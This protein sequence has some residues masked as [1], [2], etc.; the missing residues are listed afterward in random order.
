MP[1]QPTSL[2]KP[3]N[4]IF[5]FNFYAVS[6]VGHNACRHIVWLL[7]VLEE[8]GLKT[9]I[10]TQHATMASFFSDTASYFMEFCP[11][12]RSTDLQSRHNRP[13]RLPPVP[14]PAL[15]NLTWPGGAALDGLLTPPGFELGSAEADFWSKQTA[16]FCSLLRTSPLEARPRDEKGPSSQPAQWL[17]KM[18]SHLLHTM[19]KCVQRRVL[20]TVCH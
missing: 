10:R 19:I 17:L 3:L 9:E 18:R 15:L 8:K 2:T 11:S 20:N 4:L 14:S 1:R 13:S 6:P 7:Y 5:I 12:C 16:V